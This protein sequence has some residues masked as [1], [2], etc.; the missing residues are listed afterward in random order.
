MRIKIVLLDNEKQFG[1][2]VAVIISGLDE[3]FFKDLKTPITGIEV[4]PTTTPQEAF[5]LIKKGDISLLSLDIE[6]DSNVLGNKEYEKLFFDGTA[7]PCIVVSAVID[8][9]VTKEQVTDKGV[10]E[11][12]QIVRGDTNV[13]YRL[14]EATCRVLGDRN[15]KIIQIQTYVNLLKV[16]NNLVQFNGEEKNVQKWID[17]II[18]GNHSPIDERQIIPLLVRECINQ[19]RINQDHNFGFKREE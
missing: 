19:S 2:D 15:S 16:K 3:N 8:K 9:L 4:I 18:E 12:I 11:I 7:V 13:A 14:A 6:L 1:I 10:S 17:S 5:G